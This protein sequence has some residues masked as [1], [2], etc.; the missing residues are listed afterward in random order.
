[1]ASLRNASG[2]FCG[3]GTGDLVLQLLTNSILATLT[4]NSMMWNQSENHAIDQCSPQPL[5]VVADSRRM[6]S[7]TW[8]FQVICCFWVSLLAWVV[9]YFGSRMYSGLYIIRKLSWSPLT[10]SLGIAELQLIIWLC[11]TNIDKLILC[12]L[13]TGLTVIFCD[14]ITIIMINDAGIISW[15]PIHCITNVSCNESVH[16]WSCWCIIVT[17]YNR[18][19]K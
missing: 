9:R 11:L 8:K 2:I 17:S 14:W 12:W 7:V 1:M 18:C 16:V 15:L 13:N 10:I 4:L 6:T 5:P 19:S 3:Y